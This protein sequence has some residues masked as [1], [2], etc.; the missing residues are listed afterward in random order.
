MTLQI[1][2]VHVKTRDP[3]KTMQFYVDNFGATVVSE[4]GRNG[5]RLNLHGLMVNVSVTNGS[6]QSASAPSG[7]APFGE[8]GYA[9]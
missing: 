6:S 8:Y 1:N 5:Y 7:N 3:K 2:H 9:D 4:V